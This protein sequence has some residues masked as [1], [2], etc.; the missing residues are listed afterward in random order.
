MVLLKATSDF[1]DTKDYHVAV[2][3]AGPRE[4]HLHLAA[5]R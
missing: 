4:Y 5:D 1:K 2:V 3:S